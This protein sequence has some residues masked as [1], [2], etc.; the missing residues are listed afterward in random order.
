MG[1][2]EWQGEEA[3]RRPYVFHR[4]GF[5]P[6]AFA[7]IW[8]ARKISE[9]WARSFAILTTGAEGALRTSPMLME[10]LTS[11]RRDCEAAPA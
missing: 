3:P 7:G 11:P 6:F 2:Y 10:A 8:T 5:T 4:D 1:W 9:G